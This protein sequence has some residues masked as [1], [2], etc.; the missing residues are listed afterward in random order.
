MPKF[1]YIIGN[2]T[3][4]KD[5]D[6]NRLRG[7][8]IVAGCNHLYKDFEP[9][10]LVSL[11]VEMTDEIQNYMDGGGMRR[12]KHITRRYID[13]RLWLTVEGEGVCPIRMVNHGEFHNS[14]VLAAAYLTEFVQVDVL[15]LIGVD[16][17]LP[18][19]DTINGGKNDFY[20]GNS[21]QSRMFLSMWNTLATKNEQTAF[22]RVGPIADYDRKFYD[23]QL[24]G[25]LFE[26]NFDAI[27]T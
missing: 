19:P 23:T 14:G 15:Y 12:W 2:G 20:E 5:F 25:Y 22:I 3:S 26:E 21:N 18:V 9:D 1:G 17:F 11:D 10:Y 4:R 6:L 16:F 8:G 24:R 27:F 13:G 7:R